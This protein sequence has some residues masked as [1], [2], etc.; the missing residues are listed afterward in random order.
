MYIINCASS[1]NEDYVLRSQRNYF[2]PNTEKSKTSNR[3]L[4]QGQ[5]VSFTPN[6]DSLSIVCIVRLYDGDVVQWSTS[7]ALLPAS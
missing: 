3:H 5:R 1:V 6:C 2:T 4:N 7:G